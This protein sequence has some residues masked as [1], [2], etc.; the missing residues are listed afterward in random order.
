[1]ARPLSTPAVRQLV[2]TWAERLRLKDWEIEITLTKP[3]DDGQRELFG[4]V[5]WD[6]DRRWAHITLD[7]TQ[8]PVEMES[9]IIHELLHVVWTGHLRKSGGYS[10]HE[11]RSIEAITE[12]LY[13][14][15]H[16]RKTCTNVEE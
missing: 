3:F 11:E 7:K 8:D 15:Y 13:N 10:V 12:A 6:C 5:T 16:R 4:L 1:M 9:T 14:G 2:K